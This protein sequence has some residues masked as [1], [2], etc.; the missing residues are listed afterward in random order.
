MTTIKRTISTLLLGSAMLSAAYGAQGGQQ[1]Q[2]DS[3]ER[4][5]MGDPIRELNLSPEQREQIRA[6]REQFRDERA[7]INL[8]LRETTAALDAALDADNPDEAVIEKL[9]RDVAAAQA[10]SMRMRILSELRIRRVLTAEQLA[11]LRELQQEVKQ[12]RPRDNF[13]R[14]QDAIDRQ[15]G[16]TTPRN[17]LGPLN[18][19]INP[20]RRARP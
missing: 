1:P 20:R 2:T 13:R 14:R 7:A 3:P 9:I 16:Q 12:A 17:T 5:G 11:K 8:R 10:A 19:P 4:P 6:I 18:S 15:R